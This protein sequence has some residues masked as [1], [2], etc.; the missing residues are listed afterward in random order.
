MPYVICQHPATRI[1]VMVLQ[2][3]WPKLVGMIN[4][5][6]C[7]YF[8]EDWMEL[9]NGQNYICLR[10]IKAD[11]GHQLG[12]FL[13]LLY[14]LEWETVTAGTDEPK[15]FYILIKPRKKVKKDAEEHREE[16]HTGSEG[17][18]RG[19]SAADPEL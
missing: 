16:I 3:F 19:E 9:P 2:E 18:D 14:G 6:G 4:R 12:E 5:T 17:G 11:K 7:R 1:D 8:K 15:K 13:G 10:D